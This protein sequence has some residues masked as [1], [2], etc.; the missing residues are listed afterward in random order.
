MRIKP[1]RHPAGAR[2][3]LSELVI[4]QKGKVVHI[5][6]EDK[7]LRRRFFDMGLTEGVLVKVKK[8]APL[9][10]PV[11]LELRGYE[12]CLRKQDMALITVEVMP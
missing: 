10:D 9:G 8:I 4:N 11:D 7:A 6:P 1:A 12:L 2:V 5:N 3:R